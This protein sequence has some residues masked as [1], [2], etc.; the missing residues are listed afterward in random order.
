MARCGAERTDVGKCQGG[1]EGA[2]SGRPMKKGEHVGEEN[3]DELIEGSKDA[4][5]IL[6]FI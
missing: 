3:L 4:L 6:H 2:E 1:G 5:R